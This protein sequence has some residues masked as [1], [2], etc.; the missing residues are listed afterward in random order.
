MEPIILTATINKPI[1]QVFDA[2]SLPLHI[3]HWNTASEDW[4]S[5]FAENELVEGGRFNYRMEHKETKEG[6]DFTGTFTKIV[7]P[8]ILEYK[9]DD[10][11]HVTIHLHELNKDQT[12]LT[13][14]F[15]P[16][17]TF[18]LDQQ[19]QGWQAILDNLVSYI[20]NDQV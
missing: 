3:K 6:F 14:T 12:L 10:N 1:K 20:E 19:R 7:S 16:E 9:L 18:P 13:Q 11:R 4:H 17:N 8:N 2:I 5:P 15:E